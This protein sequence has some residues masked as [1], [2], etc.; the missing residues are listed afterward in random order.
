MKAWQLTTVLAFLAVAAGQ[1]PLREIADDSPPVR[2]QLDRVVGTSGYGFV[3]P[4]ERPPFARD[5]TV[6]SLTR[7]KREIED[8]FIDETDW[9]HFVPDIV[10]RYHVLPDGTIDTALIQEPAVLRVGSPW[11]RCVMEAIAATRF[12]PFSG[13]SVWLDYRFDF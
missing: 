10:V 4:E 2:A 12:A 7:T 8:C 1:L 11:T 13:S 6:V 3:G 5:E 9:R